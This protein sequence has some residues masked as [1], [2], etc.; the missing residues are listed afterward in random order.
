M[1]C[2]ANAF[3]LS[4][5]TGKDRWQKTTKSST[6]SQKALECFTSLVQNKYFMKWDCILKKNPAKTQTSKQNESQQN[7]QTVSLLTAIV[8]SH[9]AEITI[10]SE[11][12]FHVTISE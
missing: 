6:P 2:Y 10:F 3:C 7:P 9:H 12:T 1:I 8:T 5:H 11:F 4:D